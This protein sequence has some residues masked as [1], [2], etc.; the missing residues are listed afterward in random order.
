MSLPVALHVIIQINCHLAGGRR[1]SGG[2]E[3]RVLAAGI[4]QPVQR[5]ACETWQ[6]FLRHCVVHNYLV[7]DDVI[8]WKHFPRNWPF[9]R[10][11]H[12][13]PVNS[14]HKG[15]W[16]GALMFTLICARINVWA[17]NGEAGYLRR[18][19]AHY[20]VIVMFK[21][22]FHQPMLSSCMETFFILLAVC[23]WNP[24][25]TGGPLKRN[26]GVCR[27]PELADEE[28]VVL[29][30]IQYA[31][32]LMWRRCDRHLILK[33]VVVTWMKQKSTWVAFP[34]T[35]TWGWGSFVHVLVKQKQARSSWTP[36]TRH[37]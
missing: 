22:Q 34:I 2:D 19:L 7:H 31:P 36:V 11:I 24:P 21:A 23:D 17:N 32:M 18:H 9:V 25:I 26:F 3:C 33:W 8:K 1:S 28:T 10:G 29:P 4:D 12:R 37:L 14:P 6:P 16:R 35:N 13:S 20:D 27:Q 15:Q 5:R 30:V